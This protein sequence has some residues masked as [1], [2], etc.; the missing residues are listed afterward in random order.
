MQR[1]IRDAERLECGAA[2]CIGAKGQYAGTAPADDDVNAG[3]FDRSRYLGRTADAAHDPAAHRRRRRQLKPIEADDRK[4]A[5]A[6][7]QRRR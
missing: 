4:A 5:P 7:G 2:I 3:R 1:K 6:R